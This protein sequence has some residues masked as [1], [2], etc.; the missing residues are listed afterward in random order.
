MTKKNLLLINVVE[1]IAEDNPG[2]PYIKTI[3]IAQ[4]HIDDM[5]DKIKKEVKS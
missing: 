4:R 2:I 5:I 1:C 3:K